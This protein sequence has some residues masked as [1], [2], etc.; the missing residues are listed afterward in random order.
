ME[1]TRSCLYKN[2]SLYK[3]PFG[4]E[5]E[6]HNYGEAWLHIALFTLAIVYSI[7]Y[8][9]PW[10]VVRDY[11]NIMDKQNWGLFGQFALIVWSLVLIIVP[12]VLF[13]LSAVSSWLSKSRI[14]TREV[15]LVFASSLLPIGLMLWISFVVPMLF[16]NKTFVQQ[17]L[18]DPFGWGW[19]FFGTANIPWHQFLPEFIPWIQAFMVLTGLYY[20]LESIHKKWRHKF[21][22]PLFFTISSSLLLFLTATT[23]AMLLFFVN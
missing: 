20:S 22:P 17:S 23:I 21:T 15:F 16:V 5:M 4:S 10:P 19:D 9:G 7:L 6:T 3:K 11:I 18:S 2:V 8:L 1:C 12:S 13:G 14:T